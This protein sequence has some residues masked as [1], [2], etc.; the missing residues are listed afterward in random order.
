LV[1][2]VRLPVSHCLLKPNSSLAQTVSLTMDPDVRCAERKQPVCGPLS[3]P[4]DVG[5]ITRVM[6]GTFVGGTGWLM[7]ASGKV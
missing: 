3:R 2:D 7:F 4:L 1:D 6:F 5:A